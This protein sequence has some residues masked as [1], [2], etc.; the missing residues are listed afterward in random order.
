MA[1][2]KALRMLLKALSYGGIEVQS[3]RR[4]ANL[5]LLDPMKFFL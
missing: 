5:K 1:I 4:L 3:S 2:N